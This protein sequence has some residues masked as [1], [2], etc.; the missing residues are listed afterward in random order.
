V[1]TAL[2][3]LGP[4]VAEFDDHVRPFYEALG[5]RIEPIGSDRYRGVRRPTRSDS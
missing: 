5:F 3:R 4:L 1:E 2:D